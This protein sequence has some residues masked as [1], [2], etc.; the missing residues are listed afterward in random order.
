M[1]WSGRIYVGQVADVRGR[2]RLTAANAAVCVA[3]RN[4]NR[5]SEYPRNNTPASAA[6]SPKRRPMLA[7]AATS[8]HTYGN[9]TT[10]HVDSLTI[11]RLPATLP[12]VALYTSRSRAAAQPNDTPLVPPRQPEP[13]LGPQQ[14][15][16][17]V[18]PQ[19]RRWVAWQCRHCGRHPDCIA[20]QQAVCG[21]GIG[22]RCA[23]RPLS[24]ST[25]PSA[26]AGSHMLA[27]LN[28][29]PTPGP[30]HRC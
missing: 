13:R 26:A 17:L 8:L 19:P 23:Q 1:V 16:P 21:D 12:R 20:R 29:T 22:R 10:L 27:A 28:L 15:G 3:M 5:L 30:A 18:V 4:N 7:L 24:A 9:P 6:G 11:R 25:C 2:A 14:D